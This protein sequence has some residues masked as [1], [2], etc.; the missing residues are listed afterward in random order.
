MKIKV[1][2]PH[3]EKSLRLYHKQMWFYR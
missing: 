2:T 1:Y 3:S